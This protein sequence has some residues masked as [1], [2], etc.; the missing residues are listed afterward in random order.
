MWLGLA[1][2]SWYTDQSPQH[3]SFGDNYTVIVMKKCTSCLSEKPLSEYQK[4]ASSKSGLR[5]KCKSCSYK[6]TIEWNRSKNGVACRLWHK[7]NARSKSR[8]HDKPNYT[9]EWLYDFVLNNI[10]FESIY[11]AWVSS[12]YAKDLAPSIDRINDRIGYTKDNIKLVT[13]SENMTH[14]WESAKNADF[15]NDGWALGP[16]GSH[17]A[18]CQYSLDGVLLATYIS[19]SEACRATESSDSK[20][21]SVCKGGRVTHNGFQWRYFGCNRPVFPVN[22]KMIACIGT[23][24]N[25]R[26]VSVQ[27]S[28]GCFVGVFESIANACKALNLNYRSV[29]RAMA[30]GSTNK[31]YLFIYEPN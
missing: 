20:V 26:K 6:A 12:G 4:D 14:A 3:P 31:G 7:H 2:E 28:N 13:F 11:Q 25:T 8:G 10:N 17:K 19:V 27:D 29:N 1:A 23:A 9:R 24:T 16:M 22:R 18:V 21:S 30:K 5:T 15:D